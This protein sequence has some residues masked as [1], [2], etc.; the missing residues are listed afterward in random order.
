MTP[1]AA[2]FARLTHA[3]ALRALYIDFEGEKGRVPALLGVH[4]RGQGDRPHVEQDLIIGTFASA[5]RDTAT[6]ALERSVRKLVQRAESGDRRIVAWSEHEL[7]VIRR[8][9]S[10]HPR[11][12]DRFEKRFANAR[13]IARRWRNK[14]HDGTKPPTASLPDYLELLGYK[15]P[16]DA[17][18]G[19]VGAT[20]RDIRKRFDQGKLPTPGQVERWERLIEH[21]RHDC[22]GM[23][24]VCLTAT[25]EMDALDVAKDATKAPRKARRRTT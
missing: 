15:V 23:R 6:D 4:R 18:G 8:D 1:V 13:V 9:L 21:N 24:K 20:L 2:K 22:I 19:D 25:A 14:C 7:M 12:I 5:D 17:V 10:E 16:D 3:E 11:L